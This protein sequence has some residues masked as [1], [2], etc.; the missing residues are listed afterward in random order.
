LKMSE[1]DEVNG[2]SKLATLHDLV[3][4]RSISTAEVRRQFQGMNEALGIDNKV[5]SFLMLMTGRDDVVILDRIQLNTMWDSGRY[6]KLIYD[7]IADNF[8]GLHGL[9]RYE[10]MENALQDKIVELYTR[11]GRPQDAS[12]G[13][14]HWESWV[15]NS[16][17]VVAH[18]TMQGLVD[19]IEGASSPYAFM[20][21]PEGKQNMFRYGAI[22]ARDDKGQQYFMYS[23]SNGQPYKFNRENF[24]L[25][26]DEIKKPKVGILPKNFKVSEYDQGYPWYEAEGV[27]R[28]KLDEVIKS[29]AQGKATPREYGVEGDVLNEDQ[30]DESGAGLGPTPSLDMA[31]TPAFREAPDSLATRNRLVDD[32]EKAGIPQGELVADVTDQDLDA[33]SPDSKRLLK[34]LRDD[35]WLGF[36]NID[37]LLTTIFD[38]GLDGYETSIA[39]RIALGRYVNQNYG[40]ITTS[41]DMLAKGDLDNIP[42]DHKFNGEDATDIV[43]DLQY[44]LETLLPFYKGIMDQY[45]DMKQL[46]RKIAANRGLERLPAS[47]SFYD[48][49]NL[50]HGKSAYELDLVTKNYLIPIQK[51]L[52]SKNL[53]V[54]AFGKYLL[55][56]HAPERN[57]VIAQKALEKREK[58]VAAAE[59]AE[60]QRMIQYFEETPIPFQDYETE[61]GGSGISTKEAVDILALA[62]FDGLLA[63][64]E[65]AAQLVYDMLKEHRDRMVENQLLD[66][67]TVEDWEEQ[68]QFYVP[69]K[70][71]AAEEGI[72][73]EY[74]MSDKTRGFSI[75]G[76]ESLKAKGR[77]TLPANPLVIAILDVAAK[78]KR[79]EKNKVA[80]VL[81]DMLQNSGYEIDPEI[82]EK[83][84]RSPWNIYNNK[85]RPRENRTDGATMIPLD[86]MQKEKTVNGNYRFVVVKRGGQTFFIEFKDPELNKTL[87]RLGESPFN[88][89]N[90]FW[91]GASKRA[92]QFQN[93]HRDVLINYNPSWGLVNPMRDVITAI[94]YAMAESEAKGS[95]TE[96]KGIVRKM[97]QNYPNALRAYWR[98]LRETEGRGKAIT[99]RGKATQAEYDQYVKEYF[100]DGAPT[101]MILTRTYEEEVAAIERQIKGGDV[102]AAFVAMGKFVEDFNQTMENAVRVSAYVEARKAGAPRENSA[103][104]AKDLTVNFNRKGEQNSA[105]NL[106]W[107]FFNAAQQGTL[108]FIQAVG[109]HG[110]KVPAFA[111]GMVAFGYATTVYNILMSPMDDDDGEF[112]EDEKFKDRYP[113]VIEA[114]T[115]GEDADQTVYADYTDY[116][117]KRSISIIKEDGSMASL[118]MAYGWMFLPNLGR[119]MAEWQFGI[120]RQEEVALQISQT[121]A[122]NFVPVVPSSGEGFETLRGFL[123]D[124]LELLADLGVNKNYFG[125]PIQ[126]EQTT[127]EERRPTAY[128]TKRGTSKAAKDILQ[129]INDLDGTP[130]EQNESLYYPYNYITPDRVDYVFAW[131]LGGVGRFIGDISDVTYKAATDPDAIELVD[132]PI[133]SQFY[134]EPSAYT[135]Q[136][137]FYENSGDLATKLAEVKAVKAGEVPKLISRGRQPFYDPQLL[138]IYKASNAALKELRTDQNKAESQIEDPKELREELERID[139]GKQ[140]N[141]DRFN[142]AYRK[143]RERSDAIQEK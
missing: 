126:K 22:Y 2:Q 104:F 63:P 85:Y 43:K 128:V 99:A 52:A 17:Q 143:A 125:S 116:Q 41:L 86:Q 34:A 88:Q 46:E 66:F 73:A 23:D 87:Q 5:F 29:F 39:T 132:F 58:L 25:F 45:V 107:L 15:L 135:D 108:N 117:L 1:L 100:E 18:P 40:G 96:G 111:A 14:Y 49:E 59:K 76:S 62:E 137:E 33:M 11:L 16:G 48:S 133:V 37:D 27:D 10:V 67:E 118:P 47:E 127:F 113:S 56:K 112:D 139:K 97:V 55:A 75:V 26:L 21:A 7:D 105:I 124:V 35:D 38:E 24:R 142:K 54:E 95:R 136:M 32:L 119:L 30:A 13:R 31:N 8:S 53:D 12:V 106:G 71:F 138:A 4:D 68:Y 109:R 83:D 134:K 19:D 81:L 61:Q 129:Y 51:V 102:R 77:T 44:R 115:N 80:N 84:P 70:G 9:A 101:G 141:Y 28:A 93:F 69:L 140:F 6:G 57:V 103:S 98:H 60:N 110:K 90:T 36:D 91:Q 82:T 92:G 74:R 130:Y 131:T 123:P 120:K 114:F 121:L 64:M 78:I 122:D 42:N 72:D 3:S 94:P 20:G 79:G 50:M 89:F 65:E